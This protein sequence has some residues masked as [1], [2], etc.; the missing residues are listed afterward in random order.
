VTF[1]A[2]AS[3]PPHHGRQEDRLTEG[4]IG[5]QKIGDSMKIQWAKNVITFLC[6]EIM[7]L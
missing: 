3:L 5:S 2:L 7:Q 1:V 4:Q 6:T